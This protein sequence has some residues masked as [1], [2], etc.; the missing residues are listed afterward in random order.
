MEE[1]EA[2]GRREEGEGEREGETGGGGRPPR[3]IFS[4]YTARGKYF[5]GPPGNYLLLSVGA[6]YP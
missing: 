5:P 6:L 2:R 4:F 3:K 1:R